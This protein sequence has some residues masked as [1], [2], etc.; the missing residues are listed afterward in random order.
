MTSPEFT[1]P[2]PAPGQPGPAAKRK[3][4]RRHAGV[5]LVEMI[6]VIAITGIIGAM[7]AVFIRRPIEGYVDS[8]RRAQLTDIADTALR[9]MLRDLHLALPNSVRV[10]TDGLGVTYLEFLITSGGGRYR[11]APTS[12]GAGNILDFT[13]ADSSF[14]VLGPVPA[15]AGGES[16]VLYNLGPGFTN[17]DAYVGANRAAYSSLAGSTITLSAATLFPLESP[18]N[19]F[20][21]VQY[22]V[23]YA[24]N[25]TAVAVST[26]AANEVRRYWNY[27]IVATQQTPP[28]GGSSAQLAGNVG[29]CTITYDPNAIQGRN[30]IVSLRIQLTGSGGESVTLFQEAHVSNIP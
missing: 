5:T 12:L 22:P 17:A 19:R 24:C 2:R 11:A 26:T 25:P 13:A 29:G 15:F 4:Y 23:T 28:S 3:S 14:D 9:R 30:G 27:T 18:G 21:V 6:V 20:Q 8:A 10:A 7:V 1:G 16:I